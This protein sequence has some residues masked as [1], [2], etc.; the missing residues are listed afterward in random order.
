M[1]SFYIGRIFQTQGYGQEPIYMRYYQDA[2]R[3]DPS[4]RPVY[5]WLY[6]Y[7]YNRD[8]NKAAEYLNKYIANADN[9]S[10]NCYAKAALLFVSKKYQETYHPG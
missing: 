6:T 7:Y 1:A 4:L 10:K 2:M 9:D 5:Y 8:V 3:E